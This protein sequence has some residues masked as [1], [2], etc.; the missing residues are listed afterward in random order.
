[1][2]KYNLKIPFFAL[3][4]MANITTY[5]FAS[6][7]IEYGAD[8][9]WTPMVHTDTI[10]NNWPEAEK[11][12]N[13]KDIHNYLA[14]IVGS[15]PD[16]FAEAVKI[17][18]KNTSPLGIDLN[19]AC[20]DKN[21]VKSGCGGALMTE[22][23]KMYAIIRA[24]KEVTNLPISVKTRA[25]FERPDEVLEII[26]HFEKLGVVM[27][28][29]HPRTV[30]QKFTG[31]ANWDVIKQA[32]KV[33]PKMLICGSGDVKNWQQAQQWQVET[34]CDGVMI[35]RAALGRP[36]LFEEIHNSADHQFE[37]SETK[38]LVL[39]LASKAEDIW[40]EKGIIESRVHFANYFRGFEGAST[41]RSRLMAAKNLDDIKLIL[42]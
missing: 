12:L 4:P 36:W 38:K 32:K 16:K 40:G 10:L 22:P 18:E 9:V 31:E 41:F 14:Q 33:F 11:V 13:F 29:I 39:D 6:Q 3:A 27:V 24:V 2:D 7:A 35:G 17:V 37:L 8:L 42:I 19:F 15:E 25:G 1:M 28:T 5:P 23:V 34:G 20:P 26:A 21:I 30:R